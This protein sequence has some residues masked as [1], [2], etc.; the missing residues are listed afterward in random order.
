M[1][2]RYRRSYNGKRFS[3]ETTT[4]NF[5]LHA[6]QA[7][8]TTAYLIVPP[9]NSY[10]KRKVKN[11]T[12]SMIAAPNLDQPCLWALVYVPEGT[13]PSDVNIAGNP[14]PD[15]VSSMYEPSQNVIMSGLIVPGNNQPVIKKTYLARNLDSGD[16]IVLVIRPIDAIG[17]Q[18]NIT[19]RCS[20]AI[21]F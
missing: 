4:I 3:Y 6:G 16:S 8:V 13:N 5:D 18:W 19:G 12:I 21:K 17:N 11:F 15:R 1:L 10:G 14:A 9:I 20:Y 7:S 2:R